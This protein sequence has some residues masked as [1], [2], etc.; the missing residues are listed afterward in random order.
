MRDFQ[1]TIQ[2]H[3][4]VVI[5][6][7][8]IIARPGQ[9]KPCQ[10]LTS[11]WC[12]SFRSHFSG[13]TESRQGQLFQS[14]TFPVFCR[15]HHMKTP[16]FLISQ[17]N[18]AD[19]GVGFQKPHPNVANPSQGPTHAICHRLTHFCFLPHLFFF[20]FFHISFS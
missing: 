19:C 4:S 12:P 17:H 18:A 6:I 9:Q 8:L 3:V 5:H 1:V 11:F 2:T 14:P 16:S 15:L 7:S 20:F 10:T 13:P